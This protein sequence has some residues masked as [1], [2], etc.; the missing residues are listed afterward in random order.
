M[1]AVDIYGSYALVQKVVPY[2]SYAPT[3]RINATSELNICKLL[4]K[5]KLKSRFYLILA[6]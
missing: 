5:T 3:R 6:P 1:Q 2:E 4:R